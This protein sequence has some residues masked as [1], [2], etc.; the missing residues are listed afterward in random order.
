[1][2]TCAADADAAADDGAAAV[3]A[4][5][6][7]WTSTKTTNTH[8]TLTHETLSGKRQEENT[9]RNE[10]NPYICTRSHL[11]RH[12]DYTAITLEH[13]AFR[14][15]HLSVFGS[16]LFLVW[17]WF[18]FGFNCCELNIFSFSFSVPHKNPL[19][20]RVTL[21]TKYKRC[22]WLTATVWLQCGCNAITEKCTKLR[23]KYQNKEAPNSALTVLWSA[24]RSNKVR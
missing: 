13:A 1:M 20:L 21:R 22:I 2:S 3:A 10:R 7:R 16:L 8:K 15:I 5:V 14:F 9:I 24:N 23:R 17:F 6:L 11:E 19:A 12:Y 4:A 18:D